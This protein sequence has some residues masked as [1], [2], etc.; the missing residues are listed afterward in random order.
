MKDKRKG[1]ELS[2]KTLF[3]VILPV[4]TG[5][6]SSHTAGAI[7]LGLMAR[8]IY[9]KPI[10]SVIFRLYNSFAQTGIGHGTQKGL[11]AGVL[12]RCVYDF[13]IKNIFELADGI[14]Y[15]YEYL[16]DLSRHPNSVDMVLNN[17]M[18]I[19]GDSIGAGEIKITEI[20]GF[21]VSISGNY[22]TIFLMYKD[23]PGIISTVSNIIQ[24][25]N[26]NI[27]S[28]HCDRNEKGGTAS[29]YISLD[30]PASGEITEQ[31]S[32]I[33]DVYF[34]TQIRKLEI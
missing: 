15:K 8:N 9:S 3:D 6:S 10:K 29:M 33:D 30:V 23:K 24:S 27:A 28:L 12:G 34:T 22:H 21:S 25:K 1:L 18:I 11:L 4:M 26:I 14:D 19:C 16:E 31:I 17:E 20:S 13:N 7:R 5:P 2:Q 32:A